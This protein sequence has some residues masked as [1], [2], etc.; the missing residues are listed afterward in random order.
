MAPDRNLYLWKG[1]K[2]TRNGKGVNKCKRW[3]LLT[4]LKNNWLFNAKT[5]ALYCRIYKFCRCKIYDKNSIKDKGN[6]IILLQVSCILLEVVTL[7]GLW[8]KQLSAKMKETVKAFN[9]LLR[10][11]KQ[12]SKT[13]E[14]AD[15]P[16]TP[17]SANQRRHGGGLIV[18]RALNKRLQ[19]FDRIRDWERMRQGG[20]EVDWMRAGKVSSRLPHLRLPQGA[21]SRSAWRRPH[22]KASDKET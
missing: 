20:L 22:S 9:H 21:L 3:C 8:L 16:P 10:W 19:Q 14:S 15:H 4:S 18:E 11:Y 13:R 17:P 6:G 12:E 2:N 7:K 1:T 5:M